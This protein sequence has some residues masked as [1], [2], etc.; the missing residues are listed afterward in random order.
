MIGWISPRIKKKLLLGTLTQ[1]QLG[2]ALKKALIK[3]RM[4]PKD[5]PPFMVKNDRYKTNNQI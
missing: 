4:N 1:P 2:A 5:L 3:K